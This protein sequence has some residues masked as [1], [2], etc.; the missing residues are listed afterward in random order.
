VGNRHVIVLNH[1][2]YQLR[3]ST[4]SVSGRRSVVINDNAFVAVVQSS[5]FGSA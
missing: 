5:C 2:T 3:V 4:M 1:V